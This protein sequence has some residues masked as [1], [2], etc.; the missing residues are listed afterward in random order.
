VSEGQKPLWRMK[1]ALIHCK[2]CVRPTGFILAT[3]ACCK[4]QRG[5]TLAIYHCSVKIIGRSQGRSA[6]GAA[7]YRAGEKIKDERTGLVHDY[8]RKNGVDH[9]EIF[10]PANA[11]DWVHNR[12]E[13]WNHVEHKERRS[14]SQLCREVEVALPCELTP[15]QNLKLIRSFVQSQFVD[16][17]M[18]A[19]LAIHHA[20]GDN[21]HA[22]I[23]LTTREIT[24][25]G[26][27]QKNRDWNKTEVLEDWRK[28]WQ[29]HAN[30]ALEQAGHEARI[31]HRT[32]E[33]QG[34]ERIPQIHIG[35]KVI[36]MEKRGIRTERGAMALSIDQANNKIID[37]E[38]YREALEREYHREL[39]NIT[40]ARA[41][42]GSDRA[43]GS[44]HGDSGRNCHT[45]DAAV[46]Q[47]QRR[48][49]EDLDASTDQHGERVGA[50]RQDLEGSRPRAD[51][52]HQSGFE[53]VSTHS[54]QASTDLT[55]EFNRSY[56]GAYER[57]IDLARTTGDHQGRDQLSGVPDQSL[58]HTYQ[59]VKRQ[60][61][62]MGIKLY[63]ISVKTAKRLI[64][65]EWNLDQ[66]L[67]FIPWLKRENAMG[68]DIYVRPAGKDNQGLTLVHGMNRTQVE[69]LKRDKFEPALVLQT[70]PERFQAW[71]KLT[72]K[73]LC[74][75]SS[76]ALSKAIA[77]KYGQG[78][79]QATS[80]DSGYLAGFLNRDSEL[81]TSRGQ[82]PRVLCLESTGQKASYG[83]AFTDFVIEKVRKEQAREESKIR[84]NQAIEGA[85]SYLGDKL[86]HRY[87]KY[88]KVS[89]DGLNRQI[90]QETLDTMICIKMAKARFKPQEII[91]ALQKAS[92][93]APLRQIAGD[94]QYSTSLV[95]RVFEDPVIQK[96]IHQSKFRSMGLSR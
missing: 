40:N 25:Q 59:T 27:G 60:L 5:I 54:T 88:F 42:G 87:Q 86:V 74:E 3:P 18:I 70:S 71:V 66:V 79:A 80:S 84:L 55:L 7:A 32:L 8:T 20:K 65:R 91:E 92:P 57:I 12:S 81:E 28:S 85:E 90:D 89:L 78:V 58:D 46:H 96:E 82:N 36:E 62:A 38:D 26:F 34:I 35:A 48:P 31:D 83:E 2:Q 75:R 1:S 72:D 52:R 37:L 43:Y 95:Q 22:H 23:L 13:L 24:P 21:P 17:G 67:K 16:R 45:P 14:D 15:D 64:T 73:I 77:A 11:P 44:S 76:E 9:V 41:V 56:G 93:E 68:A 4:Q 50:G 10:S 63:E 49:G 69:A 47:D 61:T 94:T 6:T 51:Q 19:D 29:E 39:K 33:A 53:P 30:T